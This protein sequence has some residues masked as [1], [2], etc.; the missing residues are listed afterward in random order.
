MNE[1]MRFTLQRTLFL[2]GHVSIIH[3]L[4]A[5][6]TL[7]VRKGTFVFD[8]FVGTGSILVAAAHLGAVTLGADIDIRSLRDGKID[9]SGK[10]RRPC[11]LPCMPSCANSMRPVHLDEPSRRR[12]RPP[13]I[14]HLLSGGDACVDVY[15]AAYPVCNL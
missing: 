9:A 8:P 10:V 3:L 14:N 12:R 15:G 5:L 6:H 13:H 2:S 4:S 11:D 1:N 7:Q